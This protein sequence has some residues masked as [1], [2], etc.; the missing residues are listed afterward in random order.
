MDNTG[1]LTTVDLTCTLND[2]EYYFSVTY[3]EQYSD[4][5]ILIAQIEDYFTDRGGEVIISE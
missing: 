2:E 5:D 3:D 1:E 4:A